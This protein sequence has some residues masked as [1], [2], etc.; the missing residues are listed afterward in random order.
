MYQ[1]CLHVNAI[2]LVRHFV[3]IRAIDCLV[4]WVNMRLWGYHWTVLLLHHSNEFSIS[5]VQLFILILHHV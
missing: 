5:F 3:V 2:V 1:K 4:F